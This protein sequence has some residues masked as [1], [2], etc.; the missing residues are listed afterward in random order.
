MRRR[1]SLIAAVLI[2]LPVLGA[3]C[4]GGKSIPQPQPPTRERAPAAGKGAPKARVQV[5]TGTIVAV[6]ES[7]GTLTLKGSK[8]EKDFRIRGEARKQLCGLR[9]G[10]KMIVKHVDRTALSVV[11]LRT[12][13]SAMALEEKK[14]SCREL[15]RSSVA[16]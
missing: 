16:Q 9:L 12:S 15:D 3:G 8:S 11:K 6:D 10:D 1:L 2:V 14:V 4:T 13:N 7:A 5:F